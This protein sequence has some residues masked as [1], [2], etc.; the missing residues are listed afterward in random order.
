MCVPHSDSRA[1]QHAPH[2]IPEFKHTTN[3]QQQAPYPGLHQQEGHLQHKCTGCTCDWQPANKRSGHQQYTV[4]DAV[5]LTL[6]HSMNTY[7]ITKTT[8]H[9]HTIGSLRY[10]MWVCALKVTAFQY[11]LK[12][13]KFQT[14][15]DK[16]LIEDD[17]AYWPNMVNVQ[18]AS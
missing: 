5:Q 18:Y 9:E 8:S 11:V 4:A 16:N 17:V 3:I 10:Y 14:I 13:L 12:P 15:P 2:S 7:C 6:W 1:G